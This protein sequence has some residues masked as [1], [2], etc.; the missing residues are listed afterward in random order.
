MEGGSRPRRADRRGD[1]LD[2]VGRR[3]GRL[4]GREVRRRAALGAPRLHHR[5]LRQARRVGSAG[6]A[7]VTG[8]ASAL[9]LSLLRDLDE[10]LSVAYCGW[11][12]EP[13]RWLI[14]LSAV[15]EIRL[16]QAEARLARSGVATKAAPAGAPPRGGLRVGAA[17]E[18]GPPAQQLGR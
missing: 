7:P 2:V 11:P 10:A 18:V 15:V 3:P 5:P 6:A 12:G 17:E 9:R 4:E 14:D 13:P 1:G 8:T 16:H